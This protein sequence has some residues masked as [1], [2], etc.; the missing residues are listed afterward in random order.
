M[1]VFHS[2]NL[3]FHGRIFLYLLFICYFLSILVDTVKDNGNTLEFFIFS[4]VRAA[5][6]C[7]RSIVS[8]ELC[9]ILIK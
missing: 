4:L 3:C 5:H 7:S 8:A 2:P 1:A 6:L 9:K